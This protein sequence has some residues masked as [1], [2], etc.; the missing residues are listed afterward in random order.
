MTAKDY[1]LIAGALA[2]TYI[3]AE[4]SQERWLIDMLYNDLAAALAR[5]NPK[6][7]AARFKAACEDTDL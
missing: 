7:D 6:F 3:R 2:K 4:N 5:D 1:R